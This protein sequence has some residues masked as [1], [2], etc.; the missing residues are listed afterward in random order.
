MIKQINDRN[1]DTVERERERATLY[2]TWNSSTRPH[3][4]SLANKILNKSN[5]IRDGNIMLVQIDTS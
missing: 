1:V 5:K 3:T 4:I 2:S